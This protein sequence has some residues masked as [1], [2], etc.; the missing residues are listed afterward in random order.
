M[1]SRRAGVQAEHDQ[2]LRGDTVALSKQPEQEM[3]GAD[4]VVVEASGLF[5]CE[6]HRTPGSF[7]EPLEHRPRA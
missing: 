3:F 6:D 7:R 2:C 5:S 4:E 1:S